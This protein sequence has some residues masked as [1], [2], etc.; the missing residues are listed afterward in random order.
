MAPSI[1]QTIISH[2]VPSYRSSSNIVMNADNT[3]QNIT[4]SERTTCNK[5]KFISSNTRLKA[6]KHKDESDNQIEGIHRSTEQKRS[7]NL[8]T[9]AEKSACECMCIVS[10]EDD[11]FLS[12]L[13]LEPA[14]EEGLPDGSN[15]TLVTRKS[16]FDRMQQQDL[17][18]FNKKLYILSSRIPKRSSAS[19]TPPFLQAPMFIPSSFIRYNVTFLLKL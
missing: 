3:K 1:L 6:L 17:P 4:E 12:E 14:Y 9:C 7:T 18:N 5:N 8:S 11:L 15:T 16:L 10:M 2:G 19:C 13:S